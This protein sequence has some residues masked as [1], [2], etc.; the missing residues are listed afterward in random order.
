MKATE[1]IAKVNERNDR[2]FSDCLAIELDDKSEPA[3]LIFGIFSS[4]G[5]YY[6]GTICPYCG[7][8]DRQSDYFATKEDAE[9]YLENHA[10]CF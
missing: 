1:I 8:F 6:I 10:E 7:P 5:A 9:T 4:G 2:C 3:K